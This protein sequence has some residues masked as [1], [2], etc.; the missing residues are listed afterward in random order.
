[1]DGRMGG[2]TFEIP[3]LCTPK[4]HRAKFDAVSFIPCG[5]ILNRTITTQTNIHT[6]KQTANSISTRC[7]S[8]CV[9][10]GWLVHTYSQ[11]TD[12]S[13]CRSV[14]KHS[15]RPADTMLWM[16]GQH[17]D[18]HDK[19]NTRENTDELKVHHHTETITEWPH[20]VTVVLLAAM[21]QHYRQPRS[22]HSMQTIIFTPLHPCNGGSPL[23]PH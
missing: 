20:I 9:D 16:N 11:Q 4:N 2:W 15:F 19:H 8:A 14:W 23:L 12:V 6:N 18:N 22:T 10:C 5:E 21:P 1:M 7:Q 3:C 17:D 13:C